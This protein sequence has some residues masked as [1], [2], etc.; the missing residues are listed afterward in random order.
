MI[1]RDGRRPGRRRHDGRPARSGSSSRRIIA[2][3]AVMALV[4]GGGLGVRASA[5]AQTARPHARG[6]GAYAADGVLKPPAIPGRLG[7]LA[8]LVVLNERSGLVYLGDIANAQ[9]DVWSVKSRRFVGAMRGGFG[10]E[11]GFPSFARSGPTGAMV[12]DLGQL[13]AGNGDGSLVIGEA[14][15]PFAETDVVRTGSSG[16]AD[17][18]DYDPADR[19]VLVTNPAETAVRSHRRTPRPYVTLIDAVPDTSG[20]HHVLAHIVIPGAGL[21][22]LEQ[23]KWDAGIHAFVM[24]VRKTSAN[25]NGEVVVIDP[26]TRRLRRVIPLRRPCHPSGMAVGPAHALPDRLGGGAERDLLL[27]CQNQPPLIVGDRTG[28]VEAS[29]TGEG[30][31]CGDEVWFNAADGRYYA[32]ESGNSRFGPAVMVIDART[33]RFIANIPI[34]DT[35]GLFHAVTAGYRDALVFV[36]ESDGVHVFRRQTP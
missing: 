7:L 14:R 22:S 35:S 13:W 36:P 25:A 1:A 20:R 15:P 24:S 8:D 2:L 30:A 27:G 9:V 26:R 6:N 17:E 3:A 19:V 12:D 34:T 21:D 32:A 28:K 4:G 16:R 11:M 29:F 31:C 23:P 33:R 5:G 10:G 18:L